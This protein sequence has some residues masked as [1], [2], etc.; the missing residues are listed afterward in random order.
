MESGA[1]EAKRALSRAMAHAFDRDD[2]R[3]RFVALAG[4]RFSRKRCAIRHWWFGSR[5]LLGRPS[6]L[7]PAL[8][9]TARRKDRADYLTNG[10]LAAGSG[11]GV[12]C[13]VHGTCSGA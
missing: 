4:A 2:G 8:A 7:F 1:K 5:E 9:D 10:V 6:R 13:G 12:W 11:W 3:V